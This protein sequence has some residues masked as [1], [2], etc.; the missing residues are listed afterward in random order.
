MNV[1]LIMSDQHNPMFTGCY[2]NS[3][4]RTPNIDSIA[5]NGVM[6]DKAYCTSPLC[7]P[8]RGSMFAGRYAHEIGTWCN[9]SPWDGS[10]GGWGHF[11]KDN[12]VPFCSIGRNDFKEGCD[13]GIETCIL[14]RDRT[15]YDVH[16]LYR[17]QA[18]LPRLSKLNQLRSTRRREDYHSRPFHDFVIAGRS[19]QWLRK[20]RPMQEPWILN[21]QLFDP[22]PGWAPP[23]DLWDYYESVINIDE[24]SEK[25]F[26]TEE[27]LHPYHKAFGSHHC[28]LLTNK[29]DLRK[30]HIGYHSHCELLDRHIGKLLVTLEEENLLDDTLIIYTSD[31]GENCGA[32]KMWGKMNMYEDSIRVPLIISGSKVQSGVVEKS[33]VSTIDVFPTIVEAVGLENSSGYR[34]ISLLKLAQGVDDAPKNDFAFCEYHA[35]GSPEG[36]FA[37]SDG[38]Y[39]YVECVGAR[40][41]LFDLVN[42]P[43]EMHDLIVTDHDSEEVD[44]L[45]ERLRGYLLSVCDPVAVNQNAKSDQADIR[46][47]LLPTGQLEEEIYTRGY[48]R[49]TDKLVNRKKSQAYLRS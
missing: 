10:S 47:M 14:G 21:V 35:N 31:H 19:I 43:D 32:H 40:P 4:T 24:L 28:G 30:A 29:E 17:D 6:F 45:V 39:K 48:E 25:Y 1:L 11:F 44:I 22:H 33:P 20:E 37:V 36:L 9:S 7:I 23:P 46:N 27:N 26:D 13:S 18:S 15:S 2:G 41:M 16:S 12:D 5:K 8:S 42:D 38:K 3:I 49:N 34:G